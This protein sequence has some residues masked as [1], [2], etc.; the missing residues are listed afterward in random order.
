KNGNI[1]LNTISR[2]TWHTP[3]PE[4]ILYGLFK[5]A[6]ACGGYYQFSLS[7]LMDE[8]IERDGISPTTIFGLDRNTM[9]GILN[10]LAINYP[11]YISVS[12]SLDLETIT[13][14]KDKKAED[15]LQLF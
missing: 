9:I 11:D 15:V 12:I 14:K 6:E 1:T 8:D 13:L 4:V 3:I 2:Q 7:Y 5:F 10:G